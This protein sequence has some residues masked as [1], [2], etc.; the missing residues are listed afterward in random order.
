M[1][2]L[3]IC[4]SLWLRVVGC[5]YGCELFCVWGGLLILLY[6]LLDYFV[7]VFTCFMFGDYYCLVVSCLKRETFCLDCDF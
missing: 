1:L 5:C 2:G 3:F 7:V 6:I 4:L